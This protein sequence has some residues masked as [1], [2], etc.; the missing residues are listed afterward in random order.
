MNIGQRLTW[1]LQLCFHR[2]F[3]AYQLQRIDAASVLREGPCGN[4]MPP[5]PRE[6]KVHQC[7]GSGTTN[8]SS[9]SPKSSKMGVGW[10]ASF[11]GQQLRVQDASSPSIA[12][13]SR[14]AWLRK[15]SFKEKWLSHFLDG[16][17]RIWPRSPPIYQTLQHI[18]L[19]AAV[20]PAF[21]ADDTWRNAGQIQAGSAQGITRIAHALVKPSQALP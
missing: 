1:S 10:I 18:D 13:V 7:T 17:C 3:E 20:P 12:Q 2:G 9:A 19:H 21:V 16:T 6:Q 11:L 14:C 4:F 15:V 5:K 8:S